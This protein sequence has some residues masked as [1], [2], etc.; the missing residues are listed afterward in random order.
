VIRDLGGTQVCIQAYNATTK[1]TIPCH[2]AFVLINI[3]RTKWPC[4][5]MPCLKKR[6]RS[7]NN[8]VNWI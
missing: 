4:D 1:H 7:G 3:I 6:E 2:Y 5:L 8:W